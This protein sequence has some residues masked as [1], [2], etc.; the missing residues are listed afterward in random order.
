MKARERGRTDLNIE[1]NM[2]VLAF[3]RLIRLSRRMVRECSKE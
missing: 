2:G 1:A 3:P